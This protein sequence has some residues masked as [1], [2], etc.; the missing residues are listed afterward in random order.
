LLLRLSYVFKS[1]KKE[2]RIL[3]T[4]AYLYKYLLRYR[5]KILIGT[6]FIAI[7]NGIAIFNPIVVRQAIDYLAKEV[8]IRQL[9]I[10]AGLII[11]IA[12][13]QGI[14]RYLMRQTVIVGSRMIENDFRNDLFAHLQTM[15]ARFF[16]SMPTGDIMSRMTND[17]N[18]V[19]AV[20]GPGI[21]YSINTLVTF[22]FV[23]W[24]MLA[25]NP[26]L[27]LVGLLPIPL[28]AFLVYKFGM[29]IHKRFQKIQA[30]LSKIS[31]KA[32]ENFSGIRI[33]KSY[34][35]EN[36]EIEAFD[37]LN[38]EYVEK[39][40]SFVKVYAA[41]HPM[42]MFIV[43][44]GVILVLF[45]GGMQIIEGILSLG[46]F[47]A[48]TLYL[49]ML[50]WPSIALGWVVGIFQQGAASMERINVILDTPADITDAQARP[51]IKTIE[52]KLSFR[53]LNFSYNQKDSQELESITLEV[54]AGSILAVVGRTGSG[55]S[56]LVNLLTRTYDPPIGTIFIDDTD[57]RE[58]P[59]QT[60][61]ENLGY[62]PQET[63]LFSD[64]IFENIRFG[65]VDMEEDAIK[66][67]AEIA[68]MHESI[69]EFP[70]KY[71]TMLG[72]RGINLSGGQ[73]QRLSIARAILKQPKIL[74]IDDA[75]SAVDTITEEKI[76]NR[77]RDVMKDKT[78]V[79]ISHR[80]SAIKNADKIIVID[81]GKIIEKGR[82]EELLA[83]GGLYWE[84]YEKQKLEE[85]LDL[86]E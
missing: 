56:T 11:L 22:V 57:I 36:Y 69:E 20:L 81:Q 73:K 26:T 65:A 18:A 62:I 47:V 68:Q 6:L 19:R 71:Q 58:I 30:Q 38:Q 84:L 74:I 54:E 34:V 82:H 25:I 4:F 13:G 70:D 9:L 43:G 52:G 35:Q 33:I 2:L 17:L 42:M 45:V 5:A 24:M 53:N 67:A 12:F 85:A 80:I 21:M 15:S 75:L 10:Y 37:Q 32:Q 55:K 60:L 51:E 14:F 40:M 61:R 31:T 86:A 78:C 29:Q 72:E 50:V 44:L 41:F 77:L 49:G 76:L 39:N 27:T 23:I 59:L 64:T 63:F 66:E 8:E 3:Q 46:E 79:W 48:F 28:M 7:S 1:Q 16:Q 83:I